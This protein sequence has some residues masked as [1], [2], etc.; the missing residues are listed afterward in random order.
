MIQFPFT[1]EHNMLREAVRDF[2]NNE[3]RPIAA[4]IDENEEVP[5]SLI[6]KMKEL[7]FFG[8]VFPTEYG[9]GGFGEVG[10]C[11]LLE[12][13][14]RACASTACVIGGHQSLGAMAIYLF[15]TEEQK[16]SWMPKL[17]SGEI[18]SSYAL[19]EPG[20]G[21]DAGAIST[22]AVATDGGFLLNGNK[23]FITNG[24][25]ADALVVFT[26]TDTEK[27]IRGGITA[28]IVDAKS[29][30]FK[31]GKSEKKLGIRGSNTTDLFFE[32][33]FVPDDRVLGGVGNGFKVAMETLNVARLSLAAQ[34]LGP[35]KELVN[36]S[37]SYANT[38]IQFG[39][40]I[41]AQQAIQQ[42]IADMTVKAYAMDTMI[43][44][45]AWMCD[46]NI[47]QARESGIVKLFCSD[48]LYEIADSAV[49]IHGGMGYMREYPVERYYRDARIFKIFE[50]TNEIQRLVIARDVLKN[51]GY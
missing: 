51:N 18:L 31:A 33:V 10:Y 23:I 47:L 43:Y 5:R 40:P 15:S 50:G 44:R 20:A 35:A 45:T 42:M 28:F 49:Q 3:I 22:S 13:V 11:V 16:Q 46:Q 24:G 8:V 19:T 21:S 37:A 27:R 26:V 4:S 25:I 32:N 1:E 14:S 9:G 17:A 12:E 29:K 6:D 7:G 34:C 38:R 2:T 48:A 39:K 41:A 36:M 30:G